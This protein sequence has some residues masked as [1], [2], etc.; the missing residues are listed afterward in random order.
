MEDLIL[1]LIILFVAAA[2]GTIIEKNHY[3]KIKEREIKHFRYPMVSFEKKVLPNN[4]KIEKAELV[5]G[6]V[7][8]AADGF[9]GFI[10]GLKN[11][12]GGRVTPYESVLDRARRE[13]LL[14]MKESALGADIIVNAKIETT[15]LI[16]IN[17]GK[18]ANPQVS[19][20][21]YGTAI[22]YARS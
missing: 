9:K 18:K 15:N 11:I 20:L 10:S 16:D 7:V 3:K 8:L 1:F 22:T 6:S 12:F 14:R 2:S 13:A 4:K 17:T 21:A 19:I 5:C